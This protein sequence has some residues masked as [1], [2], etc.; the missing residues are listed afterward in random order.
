MQ[1]IN[2]T[3]SDGLKLAALAWDN[4]KAPVSV[5]LMHMMPAAKES[6][7]PLAD[8]LSGK[9][10]YNVL[11]FDFRGHGESQ[12]GNYEDFTPEQHQQYY[13]DLE[14][15]LS[16][17][18]QHFPDTEIYLGG[19]S[20]GANMAIKY[21]AEHHEIK[22]AVALSAGLDYYGVKGEELVTK[23]DPSQDLLLVAAAD[24]MRK[25]GT[26]AS[27]QAEILYDLANCQKEKLIFQTGGH[28]TAMLAAHPDLS[29][30]IQDFFDN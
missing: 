21:L 30:T 11:A 13:L 18:K 28:G 27:R 8:E 15:A 4:N 2:F 10:G 3:T 26:A 22:K 20:I 23:T 29:Q 14:A 19:A 24:D 5:I 17:A 6:W 9:G 16:Y 1:K 7:I 12:G 25:S